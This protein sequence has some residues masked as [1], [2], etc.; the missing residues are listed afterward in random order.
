MSFS[1]KNNSTWFPKR[2]K[3]G[4]FRRV[5]ECI[6]AYE[7]SLQSG[8]STQ[9][10]SQQRMLVV[11]KCLQKNVSVLTYY[12]GTDEHD[13]L[14]HKGGIPIGYVHVNFLS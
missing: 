7:A 1:L 9:Y 4:N 14:I 6:Y 10:M 5:L 13:S 3:K 2:E 12:K 11:S 8:M